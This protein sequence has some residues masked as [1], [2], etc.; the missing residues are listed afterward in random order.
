MR[1]IAVVLFSFFLPLS[2]RIATYIT[3]I[4]FVLWIISGQPIK[5]IRQLRKKSIWPVLGLFLLYLV[6]LSWSA[7]PETGLRELETKLSLLVFPLLFF[8]SPVQHEPVIPSIRVSFI[9][10]LCGA[11]LISYVAAASNYLE[12]GLNTFS[13]KELGAPLRFHPTYFALYLNFGIILAVDA[14]LKK[15]DNRFL[16]RI[17]VGN[18]VLFI[19]LLAARM[20]L[21]LLLV[22]GL[23]WFLWWGY[24]K[25]KLL[26]GIA[27]AFVALLLL[28]AIAWSI[29]TTRNRINRAITEW[30][31]PQ[32]DAGNIRLELWAAAQTAWAESP[33]W[34]TGTGGGMP[35]LERKYRQIDCAEC[36][37]GPLNAHNQYLQTAVELGLIGL[38]FWILSLLFPFIIR[39]G[40]KQQLLVFFLILFALSTLTESMLATQRGAMFFGFFYA[41]FLWNE[42]Q[43]QLI[44][45]KSK[46]D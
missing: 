34:G 18:A 37:D 8:L 3:A 35:A 30:R 39:N 46:V 38:L 23:I 7:Y 24:Q 33:I 15:K 10:G 41:F 21:I 27:R 43:F 25:G 9:L 17:F 28:S 44:G 2:P 13:Y 5:H 19:F 26:G 22:V 36:L 1:T 45:E 14:I 4:W 31:A 42:T 16:Y 29:P 40:R 12:T 20:Q 32:V 6:G 11:M